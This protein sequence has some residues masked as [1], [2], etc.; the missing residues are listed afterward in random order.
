MVRVYSVQGL[1]V[2]RLYVS[3]SAPVDRRLTL[4]NS[5]ALHSPLYSVYSTP[6]LYTLETVHCHTLYSNRRLLSLSLTGKTLIT[7]VR[8]CPDWPTLTSP[9]FPAH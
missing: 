4:P 6:T 3:V 1:V 8:P 5:G 2:W 9:E 7:R